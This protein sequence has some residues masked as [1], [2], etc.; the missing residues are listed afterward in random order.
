MVGTHVKSISPECINII[1]CQA[2]AVK[3]IPNALKT[4][5]HKVLKIVNFIQSRPLNSRIFSELY[6]EMGSSYT[7]LLLHIEV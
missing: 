6:D 4:V 3:K 2:L 1:H 7:T 5:L